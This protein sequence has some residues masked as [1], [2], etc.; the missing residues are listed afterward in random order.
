MAQPANGATAN[1]ATNGEWATVGQLREL[2]EGGK[3]AEA[4][5][6]LSRCSS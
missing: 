3:V 1:G 5:G 2:P 6:G 4:G